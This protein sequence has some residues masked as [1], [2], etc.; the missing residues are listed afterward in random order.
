MK[1]GVWLPFREKL[2]SVGVEHPGYL[3]K[4]VRDKI[5]KALESEKNIEL[6][7]NLDFRKAIVHNGSV[8]LD[9]F[10][11]DDLDVFIWFGELGRGS[12][13]MYPIEIL[14]AIS[15]KCKVINNPIAYE[16]GL[17]KYLSLELLRKNG[18]LVPE[19]MLIS[20][21][22]VEAAREI[23]KKWKK[24]AIK[25][26]NGSY[27]IGMVYVED[28]QTF[29]DILDYASRN[30]VHYIEKFVPNNMEEWIGVNVVNNKIIYGYGKE[31]SQIKNWKVQD[32]SRQGGHMIL[33]RPNE[34]Q[35]EIALKIG[36][37]TGLDIYGVDIIKGLDNK[38]YVV[39]VNTFPGLYPELLEKA[40]NDMYKEIAEI[41]KRKR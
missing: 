3:L 30:G 27:G 17:D 19:I 21:D 32:R 13:R 36:K 23:F 28:E 14:K 18:I 20:Q 40:E 33:K 7:T 35:K 2:T 34:E 1:V 10:C 29:V 26:R 25:P 39:D 4:E 24:A 31:K 37:L 5:V 15:N 9:G 12:K 41:V 8:Y 11:F 38:Y 16:I 22:G 6:F